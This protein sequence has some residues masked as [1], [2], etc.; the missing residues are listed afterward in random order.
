MKSESPLQLHAAALARIPPSFR[1][2]LEKFQHRLDRLFGSRL[3]SWTLFGF[4]ATGELPTP[5]RRAQHVLVLDQ[6]DLD[7]LR[8]L[9]PEG[10][11]FGPIGLAAPLIMTPAYVQTSLDAFPLEFLEIH[12]RRLTLAGAD[13]FANLELREAD[14]RLECEREVKGILLGMRQGL[15]SAGD[16]LVL[17]AQV[18]RNAIAALERLLAGLTWLKGER[19]YLPPHQRLTLVENATGASLAAA[20]ASLS[21][22]RRCEWP[23]YTTLYADLETLRKIVDAW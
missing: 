13:L 15:L 9:A 22:R 1:H 17:L 10:L 23:Q 11:V 21:P 7:L 4:A 3:V 16:D 5:E 19:A 20:R 8:Q 12:Q 6:V 18:E 2:A 14:V